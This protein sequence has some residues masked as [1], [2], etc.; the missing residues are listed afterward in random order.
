MRKYAVGICLIKNGLRARF[1][2]YQMKSKMKNKEIE[3]IETQ[4]SVMLVIGSNQGEVLYLSQV[5][6]SNLIA[7]IKELSELEDYP[8]SVQDYQLDDIGQ[9]IY[10]IEN[11]E[12]LKSIVGVFSNMSWN[13]AKGVVGLLSREGIVASLVVAY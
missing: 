8:I 13:T 11:K 6:G 1:F 4:P 2:T 9:E 10:V 12:Y 7:L 5:G 3:V